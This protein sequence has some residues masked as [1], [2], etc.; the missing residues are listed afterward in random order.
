MNGI[1]DDS[2]LNKLN[3][4]ALSDL[5]KSLNIKSNDETSDERDIIEAFH[6]NIVKE[7]N[8]NNR[9]LEYVLEFEKNI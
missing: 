4:C 2:V 5:S 6:R 3:A 8:K 7:I 1:A 9:F